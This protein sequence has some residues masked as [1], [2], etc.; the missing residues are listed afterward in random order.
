MFTANGAFALES[1]GDEFVSTC[2]Q[3]ITRSCEQAF[4]RVGLRV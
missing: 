4:E 2:K 1:S 3:S